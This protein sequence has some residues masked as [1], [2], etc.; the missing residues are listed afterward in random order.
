[1]LSESYVQWVNRMIVLDA[2]SKAQA[3]VPLKRKESL[4]EFFAARSSR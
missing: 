3:M 2:Q 1:M 4:R